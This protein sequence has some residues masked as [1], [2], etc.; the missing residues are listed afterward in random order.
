VDDEL[1]IGRPT[2][3]AAATCYDVLR[4]FRQTLL[5][6]FMVS[7]T[8]AKAPPSWAFVSRRKGEEG[9]RPGAEGPKALG[10][11]AGMR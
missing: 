5:P 1:E 6:Q 9:P 7:H 8:R 4:P 2:T 11:A 10:A 3:V